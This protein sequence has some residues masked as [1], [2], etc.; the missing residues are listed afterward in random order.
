MNTEQNLRVQEAIRDYC[1]TTGD[2]YEDVKNEL[3][4]AWNHKPYLSARVN[5]ETFVRLMAIMRRVDKEGESKLIN[6]SVD[7]S[8]SKS[9]GS[10]SKEML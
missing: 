4:Q 1:E 7:P 9:N 3:I 6:K 10:P 2:N 8:A 5:F